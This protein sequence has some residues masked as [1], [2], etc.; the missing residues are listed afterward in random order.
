MSMLHIGGYHPHLLSFAPEERFYEVV[1][2]EC[3]NRSVGCDIPGKNTFVRWVYARNPCDFFH[4]HI[5]KHAEAT[6]AKNI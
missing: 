4:D 2:I 6:E 5:S 1:S 3:M